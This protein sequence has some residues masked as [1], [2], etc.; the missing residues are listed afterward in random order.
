MLACTGKLTSTCQNTESERTVEYIC[1][2]T[3][4]QH[5]CC[6]VVARFSVTV[7]SFCLL[8]GSVIQIP[9]RG[10]ISTIDRKIHLERSAELG[11]G[12]LFTRKKR[13]SMF[14]YCSFE[15]PWYQEFARYLQNHDLGKK[16]RAL[17]GAQR[18]LQ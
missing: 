11:D 6:V 7:L 9:E 12:L 4:G 16:K 13:S 14:R 1:V 10:S 5:C 3:A 8:R 18:N 17:S 2:W 15:N